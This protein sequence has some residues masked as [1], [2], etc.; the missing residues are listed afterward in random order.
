MP[1]AAPVITDLDTTASY[2]ENQTILLDQAP[3]ITIQDAE[4]DALDGG[5]GNYDGA[6]LIVQRAGGA[7]LD[8]QFS[9]DPDILAAAGILVFGVPP[10]M[11]PDIATTTDG[12]HFGA[13]GA[14]RIEFRGGATTELVNTLVRAIRYQN[15]SDTPPASVAIEYVFDD[16]DPTGP[17][18]TTETIT[19]NITD[20]NDQPS[21]ANL[22]GE[23]YTENQTILL[24]H[25]TDVTIS[26]VEL[27]QLG[28][29]L[30]NYDGATLVVQRAGGA[31]S[32][33]VFSFDPAAL[34]AVGISI[35][36]VPPVMTP[37]IATTIDGN[38]FGAGG[39]LRIAFHAG[40]TTLLVNA[41][42]QAIRYE[43]ASDDP[44]PSVS[45]SYTFDDGDPSGAQSVTQT[46]SVDITAQND[47]PVITGDLAGAVDEGGSYVITT[48]DLGF[49]DPDNDPSEILYSVSVV[50]GGHIEAPGPFGGSQFTAADV[51]AGLVQFVHD[52][53]EGT[54][55]SFE[56]DVFD[57]SGPGA[58]GAST[59]SFTVTP[60]NDNP[61]ANVAYDGSPR[62]Y[63]EQDVPIA[64]NPGTIA[65][66]DF[67]VLN[68]GAGNYTGFEIAIV[69]NGGDGD[70][71]G[72]A[73]MLNVSRTGNTLLADG[74]VIAT[75]SEGVG[76]LNI[77]FTDVNGTVPT[78]SLVNEVLQAIT[79]ANNS[80]AP[81]ADVSVVFTLS[82]HDPDNP[83]E[84]VFAVP[85]AIQQV[86]DAPVIGGDL[87]GIVVQ[88]GVHV[89]TLADLT[90][91]D[92]DTSPFDLEFN[93]LPEN[94]ING[95]VRTSGIATGSF[96]LDD[97]QNGRVT[98]VHDGS[99]TATA[100]FFF[101]LLDTS[102][103][104]GGA[105]FQLTVD[106]DDDAPVLT[107]GGGAATWS[108]TATENASSRLVTII[109]DPFDNGVLGFSA[110][111]ASGTAVATVTAIDP[112]ESPVTY[113][114]VGGADAA[115]FSFD[116]ATAIL[117]GSASG[118]LYFLM[119]PGTTTG[120]MPDFE[121]PQD[122]GPSDNVYEVVVRASDGVNTV[123]Q[124]VSIEIQN[125]NEA[126]RFDNGLP[127]RLVGVANGATEVG[128]IVATDDEGSPVTYE[129]SGGAHGAMFTIDSNTGALSFI[130][131]VF[132]SGGDPLSD[133]YEVVV[134]AS[135]GALASQQ[136]VFVRV[137][138]PGNFNAPAI[139]GFSNGST[140][141][142]LPENVANDPLQIY[143][144]DNDGQ[145]TL[146]GL[147]WSITGGADASLF[148]IDALTGEIRFSLAPDFENPSDIG[149][150]NVYE[151]TVRVTDDYGV[152]LFD[153]EALS[154][155]V[156]QS[157][158]TP[159]ITGFLN[160]VAFPNVTAIDENTTGPMQL[161]ATDG[162]GETSGN[163]LIWSI[164]GG[165]DASF[166]TIDANT[167]ILSFV[168]APDFE[169][170]LG[171][172]DL[173]GGLQGYTLL[174]RVTDHFGAGT[175]DEMQVIVGVLDVDE[176]GGG[177]GNTAPAITDLDATRL[178]TPNGAAVFLDTDV[179]LSDTELDALPGDLPAFPGN[180]SGARL[181][182]ERQG[183]PVATD[184]FGLVIP[185]GYETIVE[186]NIDQ[187]AIV[188][189]SD[190]TVLA[191]STNGEP[192]GTGG[193]LDITFDYA[194][195]SEIADAIARGITYQNA[196]ADT[197][198]IT[199]V[200]TFTDGQGG[201]ATDTIVCSPDGGGSSDLITSFDSRASG[202]K[203]IL[204]NR[205]DV[206]TI[207]TD[208]AYTQ[209]RVFSIA[210]GADAALFAINAA[211]G[212]LAFIAAPDY[213]APA[214]TDEDNV[215][216]VVVQAITTGEEA[217]ITDTLALSVAIADAAGVTRVG[218]SKAN[219]LKGGTE[220][221]TLLGL[222]GNDT[223]IGAAGNDVLNGGSGLDTA[224]YATSTAGVFAVLRPGFPA[225]GGHAT[226]DTFVSIE[227]LIG[228]SHADILGGSNSAN[229]IDAGLGNDIVQGFGGNDV[230]I[231][232]GGR[233][234]V[235][236]EDASRGVKVSLAITKAQ[237]TV[238]A[239]KD[240]LSGFENLSG[241]A[242]DDT[243]TGS[244]GGNTLTGRAGADRLDG[245]AGNDTL[246]G[247]DDNDTLSGGS[248]NDELQG[249]AGADR[250]SGGAGDDTLEG[251]GES[252]TLSG[253]A[254]NDG[255]NGGQGSDILTGGAGNDT[256][257]GG[258]GGDTLSGG[259]GNDLLDGTVGE[260][261]VF[262]FDAAL[263]ATNVDA[264]GEFEVGIDTF[265][266]TGSVFVGLG[267][268]GA[269]A[270]GAFA[271]LSDLPA[272]DDRIIYDDGTGDLFY[273]ENGNGSS[274]GGMV[275]FATLGPGLAL[276]A[277][278]FIVI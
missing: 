210:G 134:A 99:A 278:D 22:N 119:P 120:S 135:D 216:E 196:S 262:V 192:F 2:V 245:G 104:Q 63:V 241:S 98:F 224:S 118:A 85:V 36:G 185:S 254:G 83:L 161:L 130:N 242:F 202:I 143:A 246:F 215:Y 112:E 67:D 44:P 174:V 89:L 164:A 108:T 209:P 115:L 201:T 38:A 176:G 257:A 87:T 117:S 31:N 100:E 66:P 258:G 275:R 110:P 222:G 243:L 251:G 163:G 238:G 269:L 7:N 146:N 160:F 136:Q 221:D 240:P 131:P 228:S 123:D 127:A 199:L 49:V 171:S 213:E 25:L 75:L 105:L 261:D 235:A 107:S 263:G 45:I 69:S 180:Y 95:E 193:V 157:N 8:D 190:G 252:D 64:L 116:P 19:V 30:G 111:V 234:T 223:L 198:D 33:D 205:I 88:G 236:Y 20:T 182:V 239:G 57:L 147:V 133:I 109:H 197:G 54:S 137:Q 184:T 125:A 194:I 154:I 153:E 68:G 3:N 84:S 81:P 48:A 12:L 11:I 114:I 206:M 207:T 24:D 266:L 93:V 233:D 18:S 227:N 148:A 5:L 183:G 247:E 70:L 152:G 16:H 214:D 166:F 79:Y 124:T 167:G 80:D 113:S 65:D 211:T 200:Y 248:G 273:D 232:G 230:L 39:A 101:T 35:T 142:T 149:A 145:F 17:L 208:A 237:N 272:A 268:P 225:I 43:N 27:D 14:L 256:L 97:L 122:A 177:G 165:D 277:D 28:G 32:D 271:L 1:N 151:V 41:L 47:A 189:V 191:H 55:A 220:G 52:G 42:V 77:A 61:P 276:S 218:T 94:Q 126:P 132:Y 71:L 204:E 106:P 102:E 138:N 195:G 231:G 156:E 92:P 179:N 90:V 9:F 219:T 187:T 59:F 140:A 6:T 72:L 212:A 139:S 162:D 29:G 91:T 53:D 203:A 188:L 86:N 50:T 74:N 172:F 60:V 168:N 249:G 144:S 15:A 173:G 264:V 170:F 267:A 121:N 23:V 56:V 250:L 274:N 141:T 4:R 229:R 158:V 129:I 226:G 58:G 244:S 96:T 78:T 217:G 34:S 159:V 265:H 270:A 26:D 181:V 51:E 13:L 76:T 255:L 10:V 150:D 259:A 82:D 253:G 169:N 178:V 62:P 128:T 155:T 186:F 175:F 73:A 37:D 21:I 260:M 103:P 46:I 40:A